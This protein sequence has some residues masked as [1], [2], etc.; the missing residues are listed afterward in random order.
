M[1]SSLEPRGGLN[2][3]WSLAENGWNTGMDANLLRIGRFGF[4][5]SVKDRG[6]SAP[7]GSPAAGDSYIVAAAPSGAWTGH[8]THVAVWDGAA[9]V[10]ATPR[11]GWL[12]YIEDESV[13]SIFKAGAWSS[14]VAI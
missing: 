6:L 8:A 9:W 1:P 12:A 14:G 7:P 11:L 13:L 4:H 3:G 5:L 2:Y 10:F